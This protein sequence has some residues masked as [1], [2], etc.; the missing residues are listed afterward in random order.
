[1]KNTFIRVLSGLTAV[2]VIFFFSKYIRSQETWGETA[3]DVVYNYYTKLI[4]GIV[5]PESL[6]ISLDL[7]Y[8]TP[9]IL[10][11]FQALQKQY[12]EV[13]P[14]NPFIC[15]QDYPDNTNELSV[16]QAEQNMTHSRVY[17][18]ILKNWPAISVDLIKDGE[19][20][21][22]NRITCSNGAVL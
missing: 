12:P 20:W 9:R 8:V 11:S 7:G 1:M 10:Q 18:V 13:I 14:Y 2:L 6:D 19:T 15:A 4:Q 5:Q 17:V 21:K 3:K 16:V 22:I